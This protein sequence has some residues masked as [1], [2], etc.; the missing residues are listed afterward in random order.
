[1]SVPNVCV[2]CDLHC[3]SCYD[4]PTNCSSCTLSGVY[5]AY[6]FADNSSCL[7]PCPPGYFANK[8]T[9]TCDICNVNCTACI[10]N[11]NYCTAC[12]QYFGYANHVCYS[13]CPIGYYNNTNGLNC[14]A[15]SPYCYICVDPF[16]LCTVCTTTNPYVAYLYNTT[17]LTGSCL[18][19]CPVSYYA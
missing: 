15:C 7:N 8:T 18:R 12:V 19:N 9:Q 3:R 6:F 5:L 14:T 11:A 16:D 2:F 13:P 4:S 1:M 17:N 10:N